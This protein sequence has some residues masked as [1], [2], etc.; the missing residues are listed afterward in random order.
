MADRITSLPVAGECP[1]TID[2]A[3][4]TQH[5]R[6]ATFAHW[7]VEADAVRALLPPMLEPDLFEG[8]AWVS[9]VGFEM[10]ALR[11]PGVPPIPTTHRFVEFNVRTY[12]TG[13]D[14]P[15][16]W[17][18]SL[19]VPNWLPVLVARAG[20]ALPYDKGSVAVTRHDG[21]IGWFVQ[22]TWPEAADAELV[23]RPTGVMVDAGTDDLATFLTARWRLYASTRGGVVLTAPVQHEPWPL[24]QAELVSVSTGVA[25]A[26][27]LPVEGEPILHYASGVHVRVGAP[28]P[29]QVTDLPSGE[30]T[31]HFDDDCGFCSAC[32]RLLSRV[33]DPSVRYEPARLLDDPRL[34]TLSEV[35][36]IVTGDGTP[37]AGVDGVAA[38]LRRSGLLGRV[39][40]SL[41]RAPVIHG[42]AG[43]VYAWIAARRQKISRKLGLKAACELPIRPPANPQ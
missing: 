30:L 14:G 28:R 15:G 41:L 37:A 26:A 11:I 25:T 9:L 21:R 31:V 29:V 16:V 13:P 23:V 18:C 8:R 32:V 2:R 10:D 43:V 39:C 27:G 38:V 34:A 20:F 4:M 3:V 36:I 33:T 17:F 19:D 7:P 6:D 22:R 5:W 24:E 1:F 40:A 42:I 12:V 35:A